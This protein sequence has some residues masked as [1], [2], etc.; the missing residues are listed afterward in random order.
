MLCTEE[1]KLIIPPSPSSCCFLRVS[2]EHMGGEATD[3][4]SYHQCTGAPAL[5][6]QRLTESAYLSSIQ[7]ILIVSDGGKGSGRGRK[8][9]P[10]GS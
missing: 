8:M 2:A 9:S 3:K 5:C 10:S 6:T 1:G 4:P 7:G